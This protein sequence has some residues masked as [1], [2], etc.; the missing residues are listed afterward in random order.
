MPKRAGRRGNIGARGPRGPRGAQGL[1]GRQGPA[2]PAG[3]SGD[4]APL[5]VL[6]TMA[7]EIE[8]IQRDLQAQFQR[9]A[10]IQA[11]L[12]LLRAQLSKQFSR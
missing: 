4:P 8:A 9:I 10:Q 7:Q 1:R 12:D 6:A 2:G 3:R 5:R 11:D